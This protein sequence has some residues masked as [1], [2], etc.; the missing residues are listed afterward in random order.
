MKQLTVRNVGK[1][2]ARA[3][4]RERRLRG[5]SL[6]QTV[7]ELLQQA[8]GLEPGSR[9]DNGLGRLA[10]SWSKQEHDEFEENTELFAQVDEDLWR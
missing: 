2:L 10:G 3:L 7:L 5:K 8:L 9:Y 4:D 6:N 1:D